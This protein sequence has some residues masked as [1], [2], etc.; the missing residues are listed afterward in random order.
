M[1]F[2]PMDMDGRTVLVTGASSGIGR[3]ASIL[4]SRLGSRLILVGRDLDQ[5]NQTQRQL[6]GNH[7]LVSPF[8]LT[9]AEDIP[10]WLKELAAE[11]SGIYGMVHCA[12]IQQITPIQFMKIKTFD[13]TIDIN[14]RSAICLAKGFR[15]KTVGERD[16]SIVF[17]SS[18]MGLV[19]Q[20]GN[21]AYCAS[22]GAIVA[23]TKAL[24]LEFA[25]IRVNCIAPAVVE[26]PM[27]E[28]FRRKLTKSQFEEVV[29]SHPLGIG[30]PLD[31]AY[32]IAFLLADTARW[33][34][35]TTLVVDGGYS[36]H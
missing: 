2:N 33:I 4:L 12:G 20:R 11:V 34:T 9:V 35:G 17:L 28:T 10:D 31:V 22:K 3:T 25:P 27:S 23:L 7:H 15:Q 26:T 13:Q 1:S 36:A 16:G 14:L 24:A 5:L 29:K 30:S 32:S 18:V 8:D 21:S 19:G 6:E